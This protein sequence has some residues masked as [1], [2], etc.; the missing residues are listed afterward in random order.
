MTSAILVKDGI[1][2]RKVR[3]D[4]FEIASLLHHRHHHQ[5]CITNVS[6]V[7]GISVVEGKISQFDVNQNLPALFHVS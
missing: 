3:V 6:A 4:D 2:Q 7:S 1:R 5:P